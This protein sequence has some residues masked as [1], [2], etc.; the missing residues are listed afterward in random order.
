LTKKTKTHNSGGKTPSWNETLKFKVNGQNFIS[1]TVYDEDLTKNDHVGSCIYSLENLFYNKKDK[2]WIDI[3][4]K[5][6]KA[7]QVYLEFDFMTED[8]M[9]ATYAGDPYAA[10][11]MTYAPATGYGA[12][13]ASMPSYSHAS[14][15]QT[16]ASYTTYHPGTT[17]KQTI[18]FSSGC[19]LCSPNVSC[20]C[21]HSTSSFIHSISSFIHSTS[22]LIRSTSSFIRSTSSC[23]RSTTNIVI[24]F[25]IY[26]NSCSAV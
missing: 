17:G 9:H 16:H 15:P 7:G 13:T 21:V 26:C 14:Y 19:N 2:D 22:S 23:V 3:F 6:K 11:K 25:T 18:H 4:H 24:S 12:H 5:N 10:P 8:D 20:V 1:I